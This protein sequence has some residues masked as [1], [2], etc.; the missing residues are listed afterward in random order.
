MTAMNN[1][2]L[3]GAEIDTLDDFLYSDAAPEEA[4]DFVGVHGLFCAL[5]IS[6]A[7]VDRDSRLALVFDGEPAWESDDQK[8]E[9]ISL[10]DRLYQNIGST[11]YNDQPMDFPCY[12]TLEKDEEGDDSQLIFWSQAFMEAVFEQEEHWF[13]AREEEVVE[14]L[15]PVMV[16]SDLFEEPEFKEIRKNAALAEEMVAQ[17]PELLVDLYLY[18]HAPDK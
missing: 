10:L 2:A 8:T 4:L 11:L 14:M 1:Q 12:L 16:A 6:S 18:F 15:L 17:I 9:I 7:E 5:N 3:T 13:G